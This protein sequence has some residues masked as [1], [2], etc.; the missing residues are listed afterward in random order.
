MASS[1]GTN[2]LANCVAVVT[3]A[4]GGI[5]RAIAIQLANCGARLCAI[6]RNPERLAAT[7]AST[8]PSLKAIAYPADLTVDA[9]IQRLP[10]WL[11]KEFGQVDILVLSAGLAKHDRME[12]AS[13]EDLD[14]QYSTNLRSPYLVTQSLLPM[15]KAARGQIVFV[16]SS[17]GLAARRSE[18]GQYAATQHALRAI[19]DSLREEVNPDGVRVLT[20]HTGRTATPLQRRLHES[21]QKIYR[22]ELLLQPE[23]V[24][25]VVLHALALPRTA[26]VTDIN[27]RP[28]NKT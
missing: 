24:A 21:E 14:Q 20:V 6:G 18:V 8:T 7:V 26:E 12:S 22:P 19:A 17:L 13:I 1:A 11:H 15:L 25:S 23:D 10:T 4:S 5:G 3:G 16:N 2:P 27:I 9:N 28:M